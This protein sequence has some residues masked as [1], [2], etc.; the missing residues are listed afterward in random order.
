MTSFWCRSGAAMGTWV[1]GEP[2][3]PAQPGPAFGDSMGAMTIAGGISAALLA[4]ERTR[5]PQ[6]L[7]V[8]LLG[9]GMWAMGSGIAMTGVSG[10]PWRPLALGGRS[11]FNPLVTTYRTADD[12]HLSFCCLQPF[13]YWP[14]LCEA[15]NRPEL[16][17]DDRFS[18]YEAL[19]TADGIPFHLVTT[20]VHF[21]GA[22][23]PVGHAPEFNEHG[24]EILTGDLG[25]DMDAVID[26]KV[27]GAVT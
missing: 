23:S 11:T 8:S 26:L 24:D 1:V 7:E 27:K 19:T 4:R 22:P 3:P 17:T 10:T 13:R 16:A 18:S 21:N 2:D 20:P 6:S 15:I 9:T 12:R 14:S 5:E 25:L